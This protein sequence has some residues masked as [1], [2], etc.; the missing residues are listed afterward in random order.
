MSNTLLLA[1]PSEVPESAKA[2]LMK[3]G[4]GIAACQLLN[5]ANSSTNDELQQSTY[6]GE[7]QGDSQPENTVTTYIT[8]TCVGS[9]HFMMNPP[10]PF[11][12]VFTFA[13]VTNTHNKRFVS[14][15]L[16][17][18]NHT[19]QQP[20][21]LTVEYE[22]IHQWRHVIRRIR[23]VTKHLLSCVR[24]AVVWVSGLDVHRLVVSVDAR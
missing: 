1:T 10:P 22:A 9:K 16:Q 13:S 6:Q 12:G 17:S 24:N 2:R 19:S 18:R 8:G 5:T 20:L 14:Y 11:D 7:Y 4:P 23:S 15:V 21:T 3:V